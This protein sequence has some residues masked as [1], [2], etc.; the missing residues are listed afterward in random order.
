M[1]NHEE[2]YAEQANVQLDVVECQA[3]Q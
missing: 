3:V 2:N 1:T